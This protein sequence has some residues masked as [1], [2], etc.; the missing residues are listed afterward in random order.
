MKIRL[1]TTVCATAALALVLAGCGSDSGG[2]ASSGTGD[3][4]VLVLGGLSADGVLA[5]NAA[6]S[7]NSAKASVDFANELGGVGGRKVTIEVIDDAA[8]PTAAVTKLRAAISKGKPDLVLNSGPS[9]VAEATLPILNQNKILSFNIGPTETSSDPAKFP[10]NFDLSP[11]PGDQIAAYI[12]YLKEKGYAKVGILHGNS[13]YGEAY[14]AASEKAYAQEG[15]DVTANKEYDVAALDMTAQVEAIK[16]TRPD[17]LVLDAYGAPLGYVL[18]SIEKVG[19]DIPVIGNTSVAATGL[20]STP[21]PSG[22]LGTDQVKNLLMQVYAST[23]HDASATAVNEAVARM[24]KHGP[25]KA[26]LILAYNY[27]ALP[28]VVAAAEAAGSTDAGKIAKALETPAVQD[29]AKTAIINHYGFT[30]EAHHP[31]DIQKEF[32]FIP[33]SAI[34]DGQYQ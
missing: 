11:G 26:T 20:I 28:L 17:A 33:P 18:K 1:T 4:R 27:D 5:D 29:K 31:S 6:T 12:P 23:K 8:D 34:K 15:V 13:S 19:W 14:G 10:L 9:T 16:A 3:Y 32:A 7:V 2:S 25:I 22:V 24:K 21:P 30:S